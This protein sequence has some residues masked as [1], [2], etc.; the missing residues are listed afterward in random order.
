M[1]NLKKIDQETAIFL[2]RQYLDKSFYEQLIE[3][4]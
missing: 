3:E 4:I 2:V 1:A